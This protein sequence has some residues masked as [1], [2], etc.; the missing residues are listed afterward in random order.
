MDD[1]ALERTQAIRDIREYFWQ[2]GESFYK[3][4]ELARAI[5]GMHHH[6]WLCRIIGCNIDVA[7]SLTRFWFETGSRG[8][9]ECNRGDRAAIVATLR[10]VR[11]ELAKHA[12]TWKPWKRSRFL[13]DVA[14][15]NSWIAILTPQAA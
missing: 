2:T 14:K 6:G 9:E 8:V 7:V 13:K 12:R 1:Q 3:G 10:Q 11:E 4:W 15:I 5:A